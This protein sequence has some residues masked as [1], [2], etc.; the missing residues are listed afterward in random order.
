M[1]LEYF[2]DQQ[3]DSILDDS[4]LYPESEQHIL[5]AYTSSSEPECD[6]QPSTS[7]GIK[8]KP[9]SEL[10]KSQMYKRANQ[11]ANDILEATNSISI[12]KCKL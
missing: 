4:T 1:P 7:R 12:K 6:I 9:F 5:D 10:S 11:D 8:R 3:I 2:V